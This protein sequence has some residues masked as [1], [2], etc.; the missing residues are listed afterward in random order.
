MK[1]TFLTAST[2]LLGVSAQGLIITDTADFGVPAPVTPTTTE[3]LTL[4][5]FDTS[6]GILNSVEITFSITID[7]G[8]LV[9]DN[10]GT[11]PATGSL[12][13]GTNGSISSSDVNLNDGSLSTN[14]ADFSNTTTDTFSIGPN[15]SDGTNDF[16]FDGGPDNYSFAGGPNTINGGSFISTN[17]TVQSTYEGSAGDTFD[18]DVLLNLVT[19][20]SSAG[21]VAGAF[22]PVDASGSVTVTYNYTIPEPSTVAALFGAV[23]LGLV[24]VRRYLRK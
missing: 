10:D 13:L 24:M 7:S 16:D 15:D 11:Q 12:E 14:W 1:I 21:G 20:I 6:L 8:S 23:T 2:F 5:K 22:T 9:V 3:T 19:D 17:P 18:V 4:D